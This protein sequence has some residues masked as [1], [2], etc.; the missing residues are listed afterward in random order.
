MDDLSA[1]GD[2]AKRLAEFSLIVTTSTHY[3]ELLGMVPAL[4]DRLVRVVVSPSQETIIHL[5]GLKPSQTVGI[6]CESEQFLGI[7]RR[8]F[9]DLC[10]ANRLDHLLWPCPVEQIGALL[11]E[12]NVLIVPP[13]FP[14]LLNRE[15]AP[16]LTEFRQRGGRII[17]FDYQIERGSMV[18]VEERIKDLKER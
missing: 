8:K 11:A 17:S 12:H 10:L 16:I 13:V 6:L 7:V 1:G 14:V 2:P 4:Q 15:T 3:S 9:E 5:A 18:Y